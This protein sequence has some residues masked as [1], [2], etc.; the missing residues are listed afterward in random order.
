[1]E[2]RHPDD[3]KAVLESIAADAGQVAEVGA[4]HG[5]E[6]RRG[7]A[8]LAQERQEGERQEPDDSVVFREQ[9]EIA[10]P[11]LPPRSGDLRV[12]RIGQ[13]GAVVSVAPDQVR[14]HD[15]DVGEGPDQGGAHAAPAREEVAQ[16]E[17]PRN[18]REQ[19]SLGTSQRRQGE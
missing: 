6:Q 8:L 14:R 9:A 18:R 1:M 7:E 12:E 15:V 2:E 16:E 13:P 11:L 3:D 10:Q 5:Q 17:Q 4:Q 19:P